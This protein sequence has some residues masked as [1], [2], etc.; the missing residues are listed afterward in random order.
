MRITVRRPDDLGEDVKRRTDNVSRYVTEALTEK[1]SA[2][3]S[4]VRAGSF[5]EW[6]ARA[7]SIPTSTRRT[8]RCAGRE[9][10]RSPVEKP[11][12]P[13]PASG[14]FFVSL[15]PASQRRTDFRMEGFDPGFFLDVRA[16]NSDVQDLWRSVT[17]RDVPA[18]VSS[19][20]LFEMARHGRVGRLDPEFADAVVERARVAFEQAG[21]DPVGVLSRAA[22]IARGM[23]MPMA[24]ALIAASLEHVGCGRVHTSD[25]GFEEYEGRWRSYSYSGVPR[26]AKNCW[27]GRA[28]AR[29][30]GQGE[31][32][33]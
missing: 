31:L 33:R 19:V 30:L 11:P 13:S 21:V 14:L 18:A 23:G 20:T 26:L 25:G 28:A 2:K 9:T 5:R 4:A 27:R 15:S 12:G 16:G 32:S 17:E 24:D 1:S 7:L 29:C 3:G 8:V 10:G 6:R 22:R